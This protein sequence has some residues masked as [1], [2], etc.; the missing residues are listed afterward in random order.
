[1]SYGSKSL[2]VSKFIEELNKIHKEIEES[3]EID[4]DDEAEVYSEQTFTGL[5]LIER[6]NKLILVIFALNT[7]GDNVYEIEW[8]GTREDFEDLKKEFK[9]LPYQMPYIMIWIIRLLK[10]GESSGRKTRS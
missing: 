2:Y 4:P 3:K 7:P 6:E 8:P 5:S 10:K 1:V 9:Y